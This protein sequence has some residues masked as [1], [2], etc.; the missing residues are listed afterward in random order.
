M[1]ALTSALRTLAW[2]R[3][4]VGAPPVGALRQVG[5]LA[6]PGDP[7]VQ[8]LRRHAA[9]SAARLGAGNPPLGD[10][11]PIGLGGLWLAAAIGGRLEAETAQALADLVP[12]VS[13]KGSDGW[14]E[15]VARH[16]VVGP[17]TTALAAPAGAATTPTVG[18]DQLTD[19]VHRA[20]PLT[21][22]L[23]R[24]PAGS[25][26]AARALATGLAA[27][28][29]G[30]AML[31]ASLSAPVLGPD[32]ATL[33]W[34]AELLELFRAEHPGLMLEVY[35]AALLWHG[36]QWTDRIAWAGR[37]LAIRGGALALPIATLRFWAPLARMQRD[38]D[39]LGRSDRRADRTR[40]TIADRAFLRRSQ[41]ATTMRLIDRHRLLGLGRTA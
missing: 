24:P 38:E 13:P 14:A 8:A 31:I 26:T 5:V 30:P 1:D 3:D 39:G 27:R 33:N 21:A 37:E 28:P 4:P 11:G 35:G 17:A 15:C 34:R 40:S 7:A 20:S 23:Y 18:L 36:P 12:R 6:A 9:V 22:V 25:H 29:G 32:D 41:Y 10:A 2:A 19:T 16:G